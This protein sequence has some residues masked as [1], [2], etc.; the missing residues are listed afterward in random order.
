[1]LPIVNPRED[2]LC[3]CGGGGGGQ[4]IHR[5]GD[6]TRHKRFCGSAS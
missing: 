5:Q 6:L 1:M 4:T 3:V 2:P